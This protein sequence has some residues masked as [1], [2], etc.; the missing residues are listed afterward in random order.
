[1]DRELSAKIRLITVSF[2][3]DSKVNNI[4]ILP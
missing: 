2:Q 3:V 4:P 1:M